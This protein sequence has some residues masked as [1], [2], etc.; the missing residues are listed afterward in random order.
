M[1]GEKQEAAND[2]NQRKKDANYRTANRTLPK[3][4]EVVRW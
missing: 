1:N 3:L 4:P 2:A